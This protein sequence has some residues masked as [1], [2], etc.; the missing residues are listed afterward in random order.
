M[1]WLIRG[2]HNMMT[3]ETREEG[4]GSHKLIQL[5]CWL[6]ALWYLIPLST[7]FQLYRGGQFYW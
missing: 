6:L 5:Y 4:L 1:E 7:I 2:E 3:E